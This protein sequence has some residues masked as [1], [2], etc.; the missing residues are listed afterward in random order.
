MFYKTHFDHR[1]DLLELYLTV[2][3]PGTAKAAEAYDGLRKL[4]INANK[5]TQVHLA[6]LA[7]LHRVASAADSL[8]P[9]RAKLGEYMSQVGLH[10][11]DAGSHR[12]FFEVT[13]GSGT[14]LIVDSPAYVGLDGDGGVSLVMRGVAHYE[15]PSPEVAEPDSMSDALRSTGDVAHQSIDEQ[16]APPAE[17]VQNDSEGRE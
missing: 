3:D 8:D 10:A 16:D 4:L 5:G 11:V 13:G 12:D 17:S 2:R 14:S 7:E 9:V 15:D 6:H 1:L